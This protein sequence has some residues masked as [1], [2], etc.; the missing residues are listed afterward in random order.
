[1]ADQSEKMRAVVAPRP[2]GP[3]A[4]EIELR[5]RPVPGTGEVL[6]RVE[7]AG[8]NRPMSTSARVTIRRRPA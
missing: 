2:G 3:E 7:A 4:L 1:M 6:V 8:V 5:P